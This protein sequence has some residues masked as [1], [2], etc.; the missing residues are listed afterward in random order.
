MVTFFEW[1]ES[2]KMRLWLDDERDPEDPIIQKDF[3]AKPGMVW[4]KTAA[5]AI[6]LLQSGNVEYISFDHDLGLESAETGYEIAKWIEEQ[7]YYNNIARMGW[8]VHS[9]NPVGVKRIKYAMNNANKYWTEH[10]K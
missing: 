1:M 6:T 4:T 3:G 7:A 10:E 9:A 8:T 2:V 5:E